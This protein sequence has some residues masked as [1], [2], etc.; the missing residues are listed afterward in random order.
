MQGSIQF[1]LPRKQYGIHTLN[2]LEGVEIFFVL[3]TAVILQIQK[4]TSNG[5]TFVSSVSR[6]QPRSIVR[7]LELLV[8]RYCFVN[9][10]GYRVPGKRVE[11]Q[12]RGGGWQLKLP[13]DSC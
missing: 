4:C 9:F 8:L 5:T 12:K 10:A 2:I 13:D 1:R 7:D 6:Q 3:F 11:M